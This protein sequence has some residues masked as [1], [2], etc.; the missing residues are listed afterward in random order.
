[1]DIIKEFSPYINARDGTVRREIANSPEVRIAQK[2]HE[3]ESTLGQL[4]S[5]TVKFSYIDAKGA[6]KIRE[7]PAFAELQSQIQAEEARLQRLGEIANE[8]GAILDGYEAAG[9]Y[10]LQEIR[11]KHVN[12]IQSA[13]HEAWHLF[14]LAR[15]EGHSGPEH[16][17]SWLPSDLAQEP[18]YKAQEDRLRAGME[19]A[20]A[21]LEPI[22][23]D[24]Q[25]LSS[26]V[27]EA[28]SL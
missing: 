17:V 10:A 11:A 21:A 1:M 22:K 26:L 27:T 8:I 7:D 4:R 14:K 5:Q 16:R 13:P 9:I 25:K 15:G 12:T 28:N 3:L 18:G 20:K 19:A 2:H 23:A 6:M 24:L